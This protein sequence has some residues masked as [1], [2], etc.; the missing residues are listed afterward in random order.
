M[1][2]FRK[3]FL[4][5]LR[6][7]VLPVVFYGGVA[8]IF[9]GLT[10]SLFNWGANTLTAYSNRIYA[11]VR[12]NP[13]YLP[14]LFAGLIALALSMAYLHK[15]VPEVR[16]SGI[17]QTEGVM[18]GLLTFRWLRVLVSTFVG[19]YLSYFAGLSLGS[20]GPSV[21]IGATTAQGVSE[22]LKTRPAWKRYIIS[23]GAG[24]GLAVAFNAPFTG[25]VFALEE[26]H[27]RFTPML[28]LSAASSVICGT[29]VYQL[30]SPL[31]GG[32]GMLFNFG[33]IQ[34]IPTT[35]SYLLLLLGIVCGLTA[36][37][38][39]FL[40]IRTQRFTDKY[41]N[42]FPY[43]LRL[44]L[45][46]VLTGVVG[47]LLIDANSGGHG[48]VLKIA[49][50]DFSVQ[51]LLLL[52]AVKLVMILLCY[53]AGATGGLFVPM[54]AMGAIIGGI[55][56]HTFVSLGMDVVYYKAVI[57]VSMV[58]FFAAS[59]RAPITAVVLILEITGYSGSFLATAI[60]IFSAYL[61]AELLSCMPLYDS[62]LERYLKNV[63]KDKRFER[64]EM[65]VEVNDG[66][67]LI[68]KN[69]SDVL[70]PSNCL[71]TNVLRDGHEIVSDGETR[72][73][74]GDVLR[75]SAETYDREQT[76]RYIEGL[77]N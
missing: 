58:T 12:Q 5:K 66:A 22:L 30:L 53:N 73:R 26:G 33:E 54:L 48:L 34:F 50:M 15:H 39:N 57:C 41:T 55:C 75:I 31:W 43:W 36:I 59:V 51:M 77:I 10:V 21:Q 11:F 64:I 49:R 46:F 56:G 74:A 13:S 1:K 17:P 70:W 20:E 32:G 71:V 29:L 65:E 6:N 3:S 37:L 69:V 28:L 14:L 47:L 45:V 72:L 40:L 67:F 2:N 62:M 24:A 68:E 52:F 27:R 63:N 9:V 35:Q 23:G 76:Y 16:G 4:F 38:F 60:S 18:R 25:I 44:V 7:I 61:V 19:S 8:G 42:Q